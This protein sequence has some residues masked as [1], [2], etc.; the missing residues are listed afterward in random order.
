M[1]QANLTRQELT[2]REDSL[3]KLNKKIKELSSIIARNKSE[4]RQY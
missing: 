2:Q 4:Y 1:E 3:E